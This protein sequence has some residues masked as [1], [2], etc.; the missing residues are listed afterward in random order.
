MAKTTVVQFICSLCILLASAACSPAAN[1]ESTAEPPAGRATATSTP[2]VGA[3]EIPGETASPDPQL[4]MVSWSE[5]GSTFSFTYDA[6]LAPSVEAVT[7]PVVPVS[8]LVMFAESHP[9]F[10]QFRFIDFQGGRVYELPLPPGENQIAQVMVFQTS[11]FPGFGDDHSYGFVGQTEALG[12]LLDTGPDPARCAQVYTGF[13]EGLPFLPWLNSRQ[14]FCAQP[15]ALNFA[16]GSGLRYLTHYS[17]GMDAALDTQIFYTFQGL[18][19]DG[20]YYVSA[21]FP[22]Q[23]GIFP[24]EPPP[25]PRCGEANYDPVAEWMSVLSEQLN[26]LNT[27]PEAAFAPS[28]DKLDRLVTSIQIGQ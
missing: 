2:E 16:G 17:Q 6:S 21:V 23:T 7:V 3:S 28:L 13:D 5:F 26:T 20:Q 9:A 19:D 18:T 10:A 8:D 12:N 4:Q 27:Q 25:C 15:R 14:N 22:V 1:F 11:D 24:A